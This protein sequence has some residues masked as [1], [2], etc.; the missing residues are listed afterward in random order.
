MEENKEINKIENKEVN[1]NTTDSNANSEA[2]TSPIV[3]TKKRGAK[4]GQLSDKTK[5]SLAKGREKLN[6]R[7]EEDR[8][9]KEELTEKYAV[10][11]ANKMIKEKLAIKKQM[12]IPEEDTEEEEPI[13]LIQPKKPKKKQVI[14]LEE[15]SDSEEEIVVKK[16]VKKEVKPTQK[17][18]VKE[19]QT[20]NN[21]RIVFF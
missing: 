14:V 11:K 2:P 10:K 6:Q 13:K 15:K 20:H 21:L 17:E 12:G 1:L 7:W 5:E 16:N 18:P 8:K 3:A 4:K 19:Q 9:R